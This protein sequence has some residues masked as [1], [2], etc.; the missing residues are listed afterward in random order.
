MFKKLLISFMLF[1][2]F[3]FVANANINWVE[4][5][6]NSYVAIVDNIVDDDYGEINGYV[7]WL[8]DINPDTNK[9]YERGDVYDL[10]CEEG[11]YYMIENPSTNA[12]FYN[13]TLP[14]KYKKLMEFVCNDKS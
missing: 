11:N 9:L 7:I 2:G 3:V 1:F 13:E 5:D 10:I 14:E 4:Y 6:K 12:Y 8:N